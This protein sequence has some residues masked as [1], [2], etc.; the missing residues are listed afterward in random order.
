MHPDLDEWLPNPQ[1]RTCHRLPAEADAGRLW[2]AAETVRLRDA[3]TLG[4]AVRWRI[5]GTSSDLLFRD[6]FR[7]YPFTVIDEGA[8]WSVSGSMRT[9]LDASAGLPSDEKA[10]TTSWPGTSAAQSGCFWLTGSSPKTRA[11]RPGERGADQTGQFP[12]RPSP[13]GAVGSR[14]TSR[15]PSSAVR[16]C[17]SR[18]AA[19]RGLRS[20]SGVVVATEH[21]VRTAAFHATQRSCEL[22]TTSGGEPP[23]IRRQAVAVG[24]ELRTA[25]KKPV[26]SPTRCRSH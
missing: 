1:V 20:V 11:K 10:R 3:P 24:G 16:F 13:S 9:N 4:R 23:A 18:P 19:P 8:R 6:L 2:H 25:P 17:A 21:K 7:Q 12:G 14:R 15:P 22:A 26:S 5:P